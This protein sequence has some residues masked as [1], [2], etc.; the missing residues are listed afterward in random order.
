[1]KTGRL[2][3]QAAAFGPSRA[4]NVAKSAEDHEWTV[5]RTQ[6]GRTARLSSARMDLF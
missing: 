6:N 4:Y 3:S 1:M 2:R 5:R